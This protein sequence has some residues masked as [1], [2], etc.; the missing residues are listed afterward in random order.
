MDDVRQGRADD[1]HGSC[2]LPLAPEPCVT[3]GTYH[4]HGTDGRRG[5]LLITRRMT[6]EHFTSFVHDMGSRE[7]APGTKQ[8]VSGGSA[9]RPSCSAHGDDAS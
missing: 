1:W 3:L 9:L 2:A 8:V 4:M 7:K 6:E 5:Q